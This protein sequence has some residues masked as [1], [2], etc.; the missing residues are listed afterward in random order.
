MALET[1]TATKTSA[2]RYLPEDRSLDSLEA[3]AGKC[4]GCLLFE[5][6]TQTVFGHG[7]A[8]APIMLVGVI[9]SALPF[10]LFAYAMLSITAGMGSILIAASPLFGALIGYVWLKHRL[11]VGQIFG[12][13][14][15]FMGVALL[16]WHE[17]GT[18]AGRF[19]T[20]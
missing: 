4:R 5:N 11:S 7:R 10:T 20:T 14:I 15:G 6:A 1:M 8:K 16:M 19:I 2:A 12:L 13:S 18:V 9:N 17:L 3:A